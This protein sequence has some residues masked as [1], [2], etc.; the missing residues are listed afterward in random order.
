MAHLIDGPNTE[1]AL[2]LCNARRDT[3]RTQQ[4]IAEAVGIDKRT[5]SMYE[6]GRMF[7]RGNTLQ[8]LA[9]ELRVEPL[10]LAEGQSEGMQNY[11][12]NEYQEA[13]LKGSPESVELIFVEEW[14]SLQPGTTT[15]DLPRYAPS[16]STGRQSSSIRDFIPVVK[17]F[18]DRYRATRY[19][20]TYPENPGY[21]A[22]SILIFDAGIKTCDQINNGDCVIFR[23]RGNENEAGLRHFSREL[24]LTQGS[25]VSLNPTIPL[26]PIPADPIDIEI[27]GVVI[28]QVITR[29]T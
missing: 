1:F 15:M 20:G 29:R 26:D 23:H 17:T 2:R 4:E 5:I 13:K 28:S 18:F 10:W 7:P 9:S 12:A 25:L 27:L 24:G 16:P 14:E 6:N 19:P 22:G 8:R 21:P 11:F 3:G